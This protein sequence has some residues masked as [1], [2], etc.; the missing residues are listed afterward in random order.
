MKVAYACRFMKDEAAL[1]GYHLV[2]K[3]ITVEV[4][5]ETAAELERRAEQLG[6]S[7]ENLVQEGLVAILA[8]DDA[9]FLTATEYVIS[10]NDEL[11]T[12]ST[13]PYEPVVPSGWAGGHARDLPDSAGGSILGRT[14]RPPPT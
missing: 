3:T 4:S 7:V 9:D 8:R 13:A 2:M 6:L 10:K 11:F 1:L 14:P 5:E 12:V